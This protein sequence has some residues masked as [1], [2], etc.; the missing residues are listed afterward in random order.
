[1]R[2]VS[3]ETVGRLRMGAGRAFGAAAGSAPGEAS[4]EPSDA[5]A[6]PAIGAAASATE[7][8]RRAGVRC[9]GAGIVAP[10]ATSIGRAR[11]T[12]RPGV[13]RELTS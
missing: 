8:E 1:M 12:T 3:L 4:F 13:A 6:G 9:T 10:R 7:R 2:I 5:A 11:A